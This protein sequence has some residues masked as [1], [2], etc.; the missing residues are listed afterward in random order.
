MPP[1]SLPS[2]AR[3]DRLLESVEMAMYEDLYGALP[4]DLS[5]Q[6][7]V[8]TVRI[9]GALRL[10]AS[11]FDHPMF[12]RVMGYRLSA[13]PTD[14]TPR[15]KGVLEREAAHYR[16]VGVRRW[17]VQVLPQAETPEFRAAASEMGLV[18]HRGW[19]KHLGPA[20]GGQAPPTSD[21]RVVRLGEPGREDPELV[22]AWARIV[23]RGFGIPE[24]FVPWFEALGG[25][26]GW[27][28]YLALDE[29]VPA[30]SAGLHVSRVEGVRFGQFNFAA[31][32]PDFRRRGAQS[33]L[34]ARRLAD[35]EK[36]GAR[37]VISE[38]DEELP[39]RPNPSYH[40]LVRLGL[41]VVYVRANWGPPKP[42]G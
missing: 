30:A 21:L 33:A 27:S 20:E 22:G 40:N 23:T 9:D 11:G 24:D 17:M 41:P 29:G 2:G 3:L 4:E 34:I 32:L 14:A 35:A 16:S 31:T 37:W 19:A 1:D 28:L 38:T 7:G 39:D 6:I 36:L 8:G 18:R 10:T 42:E 26:T 13:G 25:R 12:N 5:R 15:A